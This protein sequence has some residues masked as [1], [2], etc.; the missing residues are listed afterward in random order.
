MQNPCRRVVY[1][2]KGLEKTE[3]EIREYVIDAEVENGVAAKCD[4]TLMCSKPRGGLLCDEP[5]LGKTI[6]MVALIL[7]TLGMKPSPPPGM[8]VY[9]QGFY[10]VPS[11]SVAGMSVHHRGSPSGGTASVYYGQLPRYRR[12]VAGD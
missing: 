11:S 4:A 5:G 1:P 3:S 7:R 9:P 2:L 10:L 8:V 6:T 12:A